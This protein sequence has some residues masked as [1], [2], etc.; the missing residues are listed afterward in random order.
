MDILHGD[1]SL[2]DGI[3][4]KTDP[5]VT[6]NSFGEDWSDR[7]AMDSYRRQ[8][9]IPFVREESPR[10]QKVRNIYDKYANEETERA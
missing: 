6:E 5:E 1:E 7:D 10:P 4:N 2:S 8:R 9:H 3:G